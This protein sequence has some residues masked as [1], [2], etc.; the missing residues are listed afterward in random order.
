MLQ[1]DR[2]VLLGDRLE[3]PRA[4]SSVHLDAG[5]EHRSKLREFVDAA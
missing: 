2:E 1:L 3:Q 4:T 5:P